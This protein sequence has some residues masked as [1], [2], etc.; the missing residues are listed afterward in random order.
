MAGETHIK[1]C[2]PLVK[3]QLNNTPLHTA[4]YG[5]ELS[6]LQVNLKELLFIKLLKVT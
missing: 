4:A 2:D 1:H 5:G 3:D 6:I